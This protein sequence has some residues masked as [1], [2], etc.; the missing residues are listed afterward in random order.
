MDQQDLAPLDDFLN[1]VLAA[2]VDR[3]ANGNFLVLAAENLDAFAVVLVAVLVRLGFLFLVLGDQGFPVG[4]RNLVIIGMD[5]A[6]GQEAVTVS[7]VVYET[8]LQRGFNPRYFGQIDVSL[9]LLP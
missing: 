5:F 1:F 2:Q 9:K 8:G 7:A 3:P 6:E 4:D